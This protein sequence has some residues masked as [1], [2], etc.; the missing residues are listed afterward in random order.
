RSE[1]IL[2][3][4]A[5]LEAHPQTAPSY[6]SW[7]GILLDETG[8]WTAGE[9]AHRKAIG[10]APADDNLHNNLGYNLLMQK[11]FDDA[12]GEFRE[13]LKLNPAS[14]V[15]H[16]NLALALAGQNANQQAIASWQAA[17][18]PASAHNNLAAVL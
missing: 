4:T 9:P 3:L 7:L 16:N 2:S 10:L 8:Q 12:A 5:F 18:D 14:Q 13:A 15:A 1:A 11:K 17:G 6:S